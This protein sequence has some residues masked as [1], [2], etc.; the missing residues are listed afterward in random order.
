MRTG[1][2]AN[3]LRN[4]RWTF[5]VSSGV[6]PRGKFPR[7]RISS[8]LML[9]LVHH[10]LETRKKAT[11]FLCLFSLTL[12]VCFLSRILLATLMPT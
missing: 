1:I 7:G 10:T 3:T 2:A 8:F 5:L 12:S 11:V 9:V 6:P 4:V